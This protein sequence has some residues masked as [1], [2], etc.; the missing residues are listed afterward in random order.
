MSATL[1]IIKSI[2]FRDRDQHGIPALD[3][4][5][6]PN[7]RLEEMSRLELDLTA[8]DDIAADG[9]GGLFVTSTNRL[10]HVADAG[11]GQARQVAEFEAPLTALARLSDG[12]LVVGVNGA[13]LRRLD[14]TGHELGRLDR[15]DGGPLRCVTA[16]TEDPASGGVYFTVG[17][18]AHDAEDWVWD[19]MECNR[20]GLLARWS[21]DSDSA[22]VLARGLAYA[23]G[24]AAAP[25]GGVLFTQSWSHSLARYPASAGAGY[26]VL[27]DNMPGYPARIHAAASGG[28]WLALFAMRTQLVELVLGEEQ[29]KREMMR[30]VDPELWVRPALRT[31][32]SH[33]EPLQGG[34][35]KKLGIRKPWAPPRS[36][37]LLL[38]LDAEHEPRE[39]LH[40]RVDGSNHGIVAAREIG[41]RLVAVSK[42]NHCLLV[43]APAG[44]GGNS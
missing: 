15:L 11:S 7:N 36:Y 20:K 17:S 23:N 25:E 41:G 4:A 31:L 35:I 33:L 8:P 34:G 29:Y 37:G 19:L 39:S 10:L 44:Q 14:S 38:R 5:Y 30:V 12:S 32:G 6:T 43:E 24:V 26:E 1:D 40:S 22:E 2:I 27:I 28:Y 21:P 13:G 16:A 18:T 9:E 3:G 42:G